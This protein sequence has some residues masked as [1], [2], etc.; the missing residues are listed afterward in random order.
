[1][2]GADTGIPLWHLPSVLEALLTGSAMYHLYYVVLTLQFYL[3]FPW[4][5]RW[6][7][8]MSGRRRW[9]WTFLLA[10]LEF[11]ILYADFRWSLH[12]TS[13]SKLFL[14]RDRFLGYYFVYFL[15]GSVMAATVLR[16][17]LHRRLRSRNVWAGWLV[18][19]TAAVYVVTTFVLR[20]RAG[21]SYANAINVM[22]PSYAVYGMAV[23]LALYVTGRWK[24]ERGETEGWL[25][26]VGRCSFGIYLSHP[27]ILF[28]LEQNLFTTSTHHWWWAETAVLW[29]LTLLLSWLLITWAD[30]I[31]V[32]GWMLGSGQKAPWHHPPVHTGGPLSP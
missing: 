28:L 27:L 10:G 16:T 26:A 3:L 1:A 7:Q 29:S 6:F 30:R 11:G 18:A 13:S 21:W 19:G 24:R 32:L 23:A 8:S 12:Y 4:W 14:Y 20:L 17:G 9:I 31:P 15:F 2:L 25:H 5:I 22:Q